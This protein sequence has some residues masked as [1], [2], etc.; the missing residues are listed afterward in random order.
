MHIFSIVF[1]AFLS[2]LGALIRFSG[3]VHLLAGYDETKV[4]DVKGLQRWCGNLVIAG[5]LT[6]VAGGTGESWLGQSDV[7]VT[8][9]WILFT[10][11]LAVMVIGA[12]RFAKK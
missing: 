11:I 8:G 12:Q 4:T 5:G 9:Q 7:I 3:M 1:G 2:V 10:V 6:L